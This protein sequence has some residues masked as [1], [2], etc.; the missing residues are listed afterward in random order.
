MF[1]GK[2][3]SNTCRIIILTSLV[4]VVVDIILIA[5]YSECIGPDGWRCKR[6]GE[7]DVEVS[8]AF[9]FWSVVTNVQIPEIQLVDN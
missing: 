2:I 3:R 7:Y 6:P 8:F 1:R 4:W 9:V 5:R